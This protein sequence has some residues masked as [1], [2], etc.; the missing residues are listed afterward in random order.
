MKKL[1]IVLLL[2]LLFIS[3]A[4]A[5]SNDKVKQVYYCQNDFAILMENAGWVVVRESEV[6]VN[7]SNRLLSIALS[8]L[9]TQNP[10]GNFF[11]GD[12]ITW[13]GTANVRP[14]TVLGIKSAN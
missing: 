11:P 2:N 1:V 13:C 14:I 10:T 8:L 4:S 5:D 6:G 7:N 3:Y 12:P 9:A